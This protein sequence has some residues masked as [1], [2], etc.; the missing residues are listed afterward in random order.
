LGVAV[1]ENTRRTALVVAVEPRVVR[2]MFGATFRLLEA[3]H[4]GVALVVRNAADVRPE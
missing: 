4:P 1:I 3:A 2:S